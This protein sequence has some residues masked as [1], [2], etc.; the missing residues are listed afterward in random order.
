[1]KT[2]RRS[3]FGRTNSILSEKSIGAG[4]HA[5]YLPG[6]PVSH[7]CIRLPEEMAVRFLQ[8]VPIGTPVAIRQEVPW[9][10]GPNPLVPEKICAVDFDH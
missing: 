1:L 3:I 2:A 6:Y 4:M 5:G 9:E 7:G 8:N 10:Y